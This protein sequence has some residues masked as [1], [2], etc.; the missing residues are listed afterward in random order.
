MH[1]L[2]KELN[3]LALTINAYEIEKIE[4]EADI[5]VLKESIALATD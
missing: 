5:K 3:S 2:N 4:L 1:V